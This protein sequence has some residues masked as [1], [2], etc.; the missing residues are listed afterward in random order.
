ML[1]LVHVGVLS[2]GLS[3]TNAGLVWFDTGTVLVAFFTMAIFI[4]LVTG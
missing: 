4:M 2:Q 3:G 1:G